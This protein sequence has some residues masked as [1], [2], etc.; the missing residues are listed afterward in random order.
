MFEQHRQQNDGITD[1]HKLAEIYK[2]FTPAPRAI[3]AHRGKED[4]KAVEQYLLLEGGSCCDK[5]ERG[6]S[7]KV[8]RTKFVSKLFRQPL[9]RGASISACQ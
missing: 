6:F 9:V 2:R 5:T 3:A 8:S 7:R 1:A 4:A